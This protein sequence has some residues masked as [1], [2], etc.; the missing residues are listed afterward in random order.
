M[1]AC[2][3][4]GKRHSPGVG[5]SQVDLSRRRKGIFSVQLFS[6]ATTRPSLRTEFAPWG[7]TTC[8][9]FTHGMEGSA[10]STHFCYAVVGSAMR[11]SHVK[12]RHTS[13]KNV[14]RCDLHSLAYE[15]ECDHRASHA[16]EI[17]DPELGRGHSNLC[18]STFS[19]VATFRRKDTNLHRVHYQ[20]AT[21][22]G[23]MQSDMTYLYSRRGSSYHWVLDLYRRMGLPELDGIQEFVS[24]FATYMSIIMYLYI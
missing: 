16:A 9:A 4:K 2:C 15:I 24:N 6:A 3:C 22:L 10:I 12:E 1:V 20:T 8:V 21:N 13:Q 18:E 19:I 11:M 7:S 14:L 17:I 23:L 5:T